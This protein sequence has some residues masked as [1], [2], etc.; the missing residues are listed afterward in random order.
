MGAKIRM[1]K[2][3]IGIFIIIILITTVI[4][5]TGKLNSYIKIK[6]NEP[7]SEFN[8][9]WWPMFHHD[10]SHSGYSTSNGPLTNN[11]FWSYSTD[12]VVYSPSVIDNK[13]YFSGCGGIT[14][15][16]SITGGFIWKYEIDSCVGSSPAISNGKIYF[17]GDKKV[18]CLDAATGTSIWN[19]TTSGFIASSPAVANGK[20]YIGSDDKNVYCLDADIGTKTWEYTTGDSIRFSSPAVANGKVYIGS[21]KIYCLNADTGSKTWEYTTGDDVV[22][23]PAIAN[24]KIYVGSNDNKI[25][26]LN[27]DTG[28]KTW[29][30]TT[31][32]DVDSSPAAAANNKVYFGSNDEKIYCLDANSG[33]LLWDYQALDGIFSSPAIVD[34]KVYVGSGDDDGKI[35]CL[36]IENQPPNKPTINGPKSGSP[37]KQCSFTF[38]ATDPDNDNIY[39]CINWDDES[40]EV[41]IGPYASGEEVTLSHTWTEKGTYIIKSKSRDIYGSESEEATFEIS[42][43]RNKMVSNP[44]IKIIL[45]KFLLLERLLYFIK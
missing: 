27:A 34:G 13:V 2:K 37:N 38:V 25:Y 31:S 9:D 12:G 3:I 7:Q 30:Y 43:P 19:Y 20:V 45:E 44:L 14:C 26:C 17:G 21:D 33:T 24:G 35:Y 22:S 18:Y 29:E 15:L 40:G 36:G 28:S 11:I 39:F 6:E 5:V 10:L 32:D 42:I 1:L 8:T 16:N 41:C 4:P 23:S